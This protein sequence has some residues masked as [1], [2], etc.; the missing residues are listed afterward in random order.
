MMTRNTRFRDVIPDTAEVSPPRD[1]AVDKVP[2]L[3]TEPP[4]GTPEWREWYR[5]RWERVYVPDRRKGRRR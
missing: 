3:D 4:K 1:G 2:G 5:E